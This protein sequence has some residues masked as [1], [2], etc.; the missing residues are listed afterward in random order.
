MW[1]PRLG[2]LPW[3]L[4]RGRS[5][6]KSQ[7][8]REATDGPRAADGSTPCTPLQTTSGVHAAASC[9]C[10]PPSRELGLVSVHTEDTRR[11]LCTRS[12]RRLFFPPRCRMPGF[13]LLAIVRLPGLPLGQALGAPGCTSS[14]AVTV[15]HPRATSRR[16]LR[17]RRILQAWC[18]HASC[19]A[20]KHSSVLASRAWPRLPGGGWAQR[21]V[22]ARGCQGGPWDL[23]MSLLLGS[24]VAA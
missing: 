5:A 4:V 16:A 7:T 10:P 18:H 6:F 3:L 2:V 24:D 19:I 21:Q 12:P 17:R 23:A 14:P 13:D 11:G 20:N 22:A 9:F 1:L 8:L 15:G